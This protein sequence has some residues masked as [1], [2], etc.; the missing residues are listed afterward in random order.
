VARPSQEYSEENL[1]DID[2][3][4]AIVRLGKGSELKVILP[5][6]APFSLL[7]GNTVMLWLHGRNVDD[8]TVGWADA[9]EFCGLNSL[10]L[11]G[12]MDPSSCVIHGWEWSMSLQCLV[13]SPDIIENDLAPSPPTPWPHT[14]EITYTEQGGVR[15]TFHKARPHLLAWDGIKMLQAVA[16]IATALTQLC[17]VATEIKGKPNDHYE[18]SVVEGRRHFYEVHLGDSFRLRHRGLS[19]TEA[20]Y[21]PLVEVGAERGVAIR[22]RGGPFF[23]VSNMEMLGAHTGPGGP[24]KGVEDAFNSTGNLKELKKAVE[25]VSEPIQ[26]ILRAV[27]LAKEGAQQEALEMIVGGAHHVT[28]RSK[29][30]G[31]NIPSLRFRFDES[32]VLMLVLDERDGASRWYVEGKEKRLPRGPDL[33]QVRSFNKYC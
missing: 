15:I 23:L 1:K 30:G 29:A 6:D 21:A 9:S 26:G 12:L 32:D 8:Q 10:C 5:R 27:R 25:R 14:C 2:E 16:D 22:Q 24:W 31:G 3:H 11:R 18:W 13:D 20:E 28:V 7:S 4:G 17:E 19:L 33:V